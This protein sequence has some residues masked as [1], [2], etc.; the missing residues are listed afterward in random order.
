MAF[1]NAKR[2]LQIG[3]P[4]SSLKLLLVVTLYSRPKFKTLAQA[5]LRPFIHKEAISIRYRCYERFYKT[6]LRTSDLQAD[7]L[8]TRELCVDDIYYLDRNFKSDLVVDGGGNIGLFTLRAAAAYPSVKIVVCEPLPQ[9]IEQIQRHL[10]VNGVQAEILPKCLG[11][12][13][14]TIPF[15]CR[16]ANESSFDGAEPYERVMEIP[17]AL[18]EDAIGPSSAQRILIKLDI[19]GMEIEALQAFVVSTETRAIYVVGELHHYPV[20]APIMERLF[21]DHGWTLEL[22]NIDELTSSFRACSPAA[23]AMLG[24]ATAV[25]SRAEGSRAKVGV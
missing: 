10:D 6:V 12:T 23:V 11:G 16:G 19:E 8:S 17:V 20:N 7:F 2:I 9:N 1:S 22:F 14:R 13:R 24:W 5:L 21:R 4:L 3:S 18:L 15:Y 25:K